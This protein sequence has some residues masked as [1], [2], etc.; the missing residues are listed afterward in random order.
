MKHAGVFLSMWSIEFFSEF[1]MEN[2]NRNFE[3]K[4]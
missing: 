2:Y 3:T 4:G 1:Y